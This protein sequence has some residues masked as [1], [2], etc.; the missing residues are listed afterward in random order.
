MTIRNRALVV[1]SLALAASVALLAPA[2]S[3][4][5]PPRTFFGVAPQTTLGSADFARMKQGK[6]GTLRIPFSWPAVQPAGPGGFDWSTIDP[7]VAGA[8][9]NGVTV[10]P[11]LSGSP[12]WIAHLDGHSCSGSECTAFAPAGDAGLSAWSGFVSAAVERYGPGGSFW[13]ANP[14]VPQV[15]ITVWQIWNEQNSPAFYAPKP[16]PKAYAKLLAA[17]AGAINARDASAEIVLGGMA[18][19]QG[20]KAAIPA[21]DFLSKLYKV[22][23]AKKNFDAVGVHPYGSRVKA[24]VEQVDAIR[25]TL[26]KRHDRKAGLY[27]SEIGWGS[28][29]GGHALNVGAKGQANR[30]KESFKYFTKNRRKLHIQAVDWFSWMDSPTTI[31]KWCP[32]SGLFKAGLV[33]KPS[34]KAYTKFTGGK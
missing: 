8:A 1:L 28:K 6:V 2:L 22:H 10:Q 24:I 29:K 16:S 31:C 14:D 25:N 3:E 33:A 11:F 30:L 27:V 19:L 13:A 9:S 7:L 20:V 34:W 17:A 32:S 4:A 12:F 15:P 23:G 5:K 26:V 18:R 21:A